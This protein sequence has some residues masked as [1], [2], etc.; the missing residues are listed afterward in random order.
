MNKT[1]TPT[2][3]CAV[4]LSTKLGWFSSINLVSGVDCW[5][6]FS[7]NYTITSR[8]LFLWSFHT[9]LVKLNFIVPAST[10]LRF[11]ASQYVRIFFITQTQL[12]QWFAPI[13]AH[14]S[15]QTQHVGLF[16][17]LLKCIMIFICYSASVSNSFNNNQFDCDRHYYLMYIINSIVPK[18]SDE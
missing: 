6:H 13:N 2:K 9:L 8:Q 12:I 5:T 7:H 14:G 18:V 17:C 3:I 10:G 1:R 4:I 15:T 11:T 16:V